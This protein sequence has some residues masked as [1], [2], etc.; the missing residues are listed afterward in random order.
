M[1]S[2]SA[3]SELRR[4]LAARLSALSLVVLA[5]VPFTAPFAALDWSDFV[6]SGRTRH[7][8]SS[9]G[10]PVASSAQDDSADDAAASDACVHRAHSFRFGELAPVTSP[11]AGSAPASPVSILNRL[12]PP[13]SARGPS[14]LVTVL[15]V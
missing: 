4:T 5:A 14:A 2:S 9:V 10:A 7:I 11:V 12:G 3:L 13:L 1:R 6:A 15:R 8:V